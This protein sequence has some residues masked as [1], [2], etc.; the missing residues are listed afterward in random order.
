[1]AG[2]GQAQKR[3][4]AEAYAFG[5]DS[6]WVDYWNNVLIPPQMSAR[7]EVRRHFQLK[8]YQR[9]VVR[10]IPDSASLHLSRKFLMCRFVSNSE[11]SLLIEVY[12]LFF[13]FEI[14]VLVPVLNFSED[15]GLK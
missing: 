12:F 14:G 11:S 2:E 8:F 10:T 15:R 3:A 1:M 9:F 5:E 4:A 6:R 7:P 13:C